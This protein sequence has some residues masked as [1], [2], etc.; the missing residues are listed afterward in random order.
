MDRATPLWY[1]LLKEA[2]VR[3][4]GETLGAVGGRIVAEVIL[5]LIQGDKQSYLSQD[6]DWT[7]MLPTIDAGKRGKDFRMVDLLTVA[8][9]TAADVQQQ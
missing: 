2:E 6:P 7:P 3:C 9:P 4:D 5:G 1:Y 8:D